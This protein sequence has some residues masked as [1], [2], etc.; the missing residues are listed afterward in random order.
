M[1]QTSP[2][3]KEGNLS[4]ILPS[5]IRIN[6][7]ITTASELKEPFYLTIFS[8]LNS[9]VLL[10]DVSARFKTEPLKRTFNL[11]INKLNPAIK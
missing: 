4:F 8:S 5:K 10:I 2:K 9:N 11:I 7:E 3:S 1:N 6:S